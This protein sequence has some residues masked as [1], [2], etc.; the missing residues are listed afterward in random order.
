MSVAE[1]LSGSLFCDTVEDPDDCKAFVDIFV[2]AAM[3]EVS[4]S[5]LSYASELCTDLGC[6]Q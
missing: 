4:K 2:P 5:L 3:P 6:G 1:K